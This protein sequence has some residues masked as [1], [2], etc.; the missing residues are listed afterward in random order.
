LKQ[1]FAIWQAIL[2][3]FDFKI[4]YIK[5]ESNSVPEF[6]THELLQEKLVNQIGPKFRIPVIMT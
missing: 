4:E 2:S 5:G 3:S 6:L 1:I